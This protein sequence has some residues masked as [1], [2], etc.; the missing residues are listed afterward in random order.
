M[1]S[2]SC[3]AVYGP[4]AAWLCSAVVRA[5]QPEYEFDFQVVY[6]FSRDRS[7]LEAEQ[8]FATNQPSGGDL[9][10]SDGSVY[11]FYGQRDEATTDAGLNASKQLP[12]STPYANVQLQLQPSMLALADLQA[13]KP[14]SWPTDARDLQ[15]L[16]DSFPTL[17]LTWDLDVVDGST[18]L[19]QVPLLPG[20]AYFLTAEIEITAK[21]KTDLLGRVS[22]DSWTIQATSGTPSVVELDYFQ[23][24]QAV[25]R[26]KLNIRDD[27]HQLIE[28]YATS[29][30]LFVGNV[31]G[32]LHYM[33]YAA[34]ALWLIHQLIGW[35]ER[36]DLYKKAFKRRGGG[37]KL[38]KVGGG[39]GDDSQKEEDA[40]AD[41]DGTAD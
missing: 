8:Q 10:W 21:Y 17:S 34:T 36:Q 9:L 4:L 23:R 2:V 28:V 14:T 29:L 1:L 19:Q 5:A 12:A 30:S 26:Y 31:G 37:T 39:G 25:L 6:H 35:N 20:Y 27:S 16:I 22:V 40:D 11:T 15:A 33:T 24:Q 7:F 13:L 32:A 41:D 18:V 38:V 3:V